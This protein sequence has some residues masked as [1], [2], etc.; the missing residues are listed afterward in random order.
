MGAICKV[1]QEA[2]QYA[3]DKI[4]YW[5]KKKLKH[6]TIV[7][8]PFNTS[9]IFIDI[10]KNLA[11]KGEKILYISG[12]EREN[13]ELV[14]S[15][16]SL[17][18]QITYSCKEK[19]NSDITF[20]HYKDLKNI[21]LKYKLV[22]FD[23]VTYFSQLTKKEVRN[24]MDLCDLAGERVILYS[25][26]KISL[27]GEK[28]ELAAYNYER[29]FIEPRVLNTRVNLNEDI[30]YTLYDYLI[31]FK[32]NKHKVAIFVPDKEKLNNVFE[33]F[34]N[35]LKLSDI[36]IVKAVKNSEI[37]KYENVLKYNNKSIVIVTNN[38]KEL[39]QRYTIDDIVVLFADDSKYNY[40]ILLYI[41]GYLHRFDT[42]TSEVLFVSN[43]ESG[44]IEKTKI[45]AREF[46]KKVWD[47]KLKK[48]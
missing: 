20:I 2:L 10:I 19:L 14:T 35:K 6:L 41:C 12:I 44:D 7:T 40:K 42:A 5:Y 36:K 43:T 25:I 45:M 15:L 18:L 26:E 8:V 17:E 38:F 27:V 29:P 23:D 28:V 21:K 32:E 11:Q 16:K 47:K 30:P 9:C 34:N 31:W 1:K 22:I 4:Y 33:Y 46:N 24:I 13:K 39:L 37:K 3:I 48:L